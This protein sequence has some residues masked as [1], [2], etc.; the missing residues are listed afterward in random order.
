MTD[1]DAHTVALMEAFDMDFS[2]YSIDA[3]QNLAFNR[4]ALAS[5]DQGDMVNLIREL[6]LRLQQ[7]INEIK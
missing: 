4:K 5:M 2:W 6:A 1:L 7:A 3:L